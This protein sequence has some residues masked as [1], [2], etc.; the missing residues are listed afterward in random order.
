MML[1]DFLFL[2]FTLAAVVIAYSV[3]W[4]FQVTE[5]KEEEHDARFVT[6]GWTEDRY[7]RSW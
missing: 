2:L 6:D 3:E 7:W 5:T 1:G 4:I